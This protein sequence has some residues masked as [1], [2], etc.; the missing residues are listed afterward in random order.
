MSEGRE[1]GP[2][3]WLAV[4]L[5]LVAII[6]F[7]LLDPSWGWSGVDATPLLVLVLPFQPVAL[8][9]LALPIV[10]RVW[11]AEALG[12]PPAR[13][14]VLVG[15]CGGAAGFALM[16]WTS[17]LLV[18]C[19]APMTGSP[20]LWPS[21]V[22]M[23]VVSPLAEEVFWRGLSWSAAERVTRQRWAILLL[24]SGVFAALHRPAN[25]TLFA[26]YFAFG[27]LAG[28]LRTWTNGVAAPCLAH[29]TCNTA[30]LARASSQW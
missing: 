24:T 30:I 12:A 13:R 4:L 28:A 8:A 10:G 11:L 16:F 9:L 14:D 18:S 17:R 26:G 6:A 1:P 5:W 25:V 29:V 23:A 19:S 20:A 15:L 2:Q 27:L 7:H 21:M 3:R 22:S